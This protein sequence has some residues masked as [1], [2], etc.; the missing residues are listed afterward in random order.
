VIDPI[1]VIGKARHRIA[2]LAA[3]RVAIYVGPPVLT[4]LALGLAFEVIGPATWERWGYVLA[5]PHAWVL[6]VGLLAATAAGLVIGVVLAMLAW[7]RASDFVEAAAQID[8]RLNAKEEILTLA[9][10]AGP[11]H[12][13]DTS[14]S[15]LFPILWRRSIDYLS[16]FDP[17]NEFRPELKRP[18]ARS[19]ALTLAL[20]VALG[21]SMLALV[22]PP[23]PLEIQAR[24]LRSLASEITHTDSSPG[25]KALA[26]QLRSTASDLENAKLPPEKKLEQ[27]ASLMRK[28]EEIKQPPEAE[29]KNQPTGAGKGDSGKGKGQGKGDTGKGDGQGKGEDQGGEGPGKGEGS[30]GK[31]KGGEARMMEVRNELSKSKLQLES[32]TKEPDKSKTAANQEK[33]KPEQPLKTGNKS[34]QPGPTNDVGGL[35]QANRPKPD[36]TGGPEQRKGSES[37]KDQQKKDSGQPGG[38]THLGQFPAPV[39]F[40]RFYKAGEHGPPIEIKDARYVLFRIPPATTASGAGK[41]V[42]DKERPTASTPYSNLPLKEERIT[43]APDERQ[44]VPPR[45]RDLLR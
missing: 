29:K 4:T 40:E 18:L 13:D 12:A 36:L 28:L 19:S 17:A 10:L 33:K 42:L 14:R 20:I 9:T 37:A 5:P 1:E 8:S 41:T 15:T 38:D 30:G 35:A 31:D 34:N 43:A 27:L 16:K 25:A 7:R 39:R 23:H 32:E 45:Y 26:E 11:K 22:R 44:L 24:K 3:L 6:R 2:E 21:L